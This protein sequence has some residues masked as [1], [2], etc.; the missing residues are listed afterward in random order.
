MKTPVGMYQVGDILKAIVINVSA[1]DRKIGLSVKTLDGGDEQEGAESFAKAE[2]V[3]DDNTP[4]T[5][6]D[7]LKAAQESGENG[8]SEDK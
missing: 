4:S 6:G 8:Q 5:F 7:L 3:T 2:V 1:K